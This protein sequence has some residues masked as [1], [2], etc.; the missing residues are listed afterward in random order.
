MQGK[1]LNLF[2]QPTLGGVIRE[3]KAAMGRA[4]KKTGLSRDLVRDKM[5]ELARHHRVKLNGG[6][7]K[8]LSKDVFEKWLNV[9]DEVRVPSMKALAIFLCCHGQF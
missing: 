4:I 7:C 8:Q 5:N 3:V 1:Q 2:N 6:N 9:E